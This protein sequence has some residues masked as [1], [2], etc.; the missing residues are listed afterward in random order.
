[1]IQLRL[2]IKC[3][4]YVYSVITAFLHVLSK[5][6]S[7]DRRFLMPFLYGGE[8]KCEVIH[9]IFCHFVNTN[10]QAMMSFSTHGLLGSFVAGMPKLLLL[11]R[12]C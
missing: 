9:F 5:V 3:F 8:H 6:D 1:M 4:S 12:P 7:Y 11:D 2:N 10:K